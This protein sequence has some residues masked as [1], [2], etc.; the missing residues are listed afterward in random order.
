[1]KILLWSNSFHPSIGGVETMSMV[2]AEEFQN[3]GHEVIVVTRTPLA[4]GAAATYRYKVARNPAWHELLGLVRWCDVFFHNH[5]SL[6]VAWP[7]LLFHR[8][9]VVLYN[10]WYPQSGLRGL[11]QPILL[12]SAVNVSCS[13]AIA[14][15]TRPAS[16]VIPNPYDEDTFQDRS[17]LRD[18]ELI[19]VGRL[20]R[21]KG[22]H[23]LLDAL[24]L[25]RYD[26]LTPRLTVVGTGRDE[27]ALAGYAES[28][29]LAG[30]VSFVGKKGPQDI[31]ALLNRHRILVVPSLWQ[32]PFGI[33]ALEGIAC[34][35]VI[36]GSEGGGLSDA[37]G[38][39]GMTF[40]NGDAAALADRLRTLL[41]SPEM[42]RNY[43]LEAPAHL[44]RHTR[45]AV[46]D[47]YLEL[48]ERGTARPAPPELQEAGGTASH[49]VSG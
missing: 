5:L 18:R 2:L 26:G 6:K 34:G 28:L 1:M 39:C 46:A 27:A 32:E 33:V 36:V 44:A 25:L 13:Q 19:F 49:G 24:S 21:D 10:T 8:P 29:G 15:Y 4:H 35:C 23:V 37:I 42:V 11:F 14:A 7:M 22:L 38:P 9:W 16:L 40:P 43:R 12:R 41:R 47:A 48:F 20:L 31:A 45:R 3:R 30:Q 17:V